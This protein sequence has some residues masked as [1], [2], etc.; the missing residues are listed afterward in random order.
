M[1]TSDCVGPL[2]LAMILLW[3]GILFVL[4][5]PHCPCP[6]GLWKGVVGT[7]CATQ[8]HKVSRPGQG[9]SWG[10]HSM[11]LF[12]VCVIVICVWPGMVPNQRQLSII[13]SDW[14]PYLGSLFS[15]Y[16]LWV[17]VFCVCISPYRTVSIFIVSLWLFCISVFSYISIKWTLTT[18]RFGLVFHTPPQ[19]KKIVTVTL[20]NIPNNIYLHLQLKVTGWLSLLQRKVVHKSKTLWYV[21]I[22]F[23]LCRFIIR[24]TRI[25]IC[26]P[27]VCDK[28]IWFDSLG[29]QICLFI[30]S[31]LSFHC[32]YSCPGGLCLCPSLCSR[33]CPFSCLCQDPPAY[34]SICRPSD[35]LGL[36][37][38]LVSCS[39]LFNAVS[40]V[41]V[42]RMT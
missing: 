38:T 8:W 33:T 24:Y 25:N 4:L 3:S 6:T 23:H 39:H 42:N 13:V 28:Y 19:M 40:A 20:K 27:C 5:M 35:N 15:H 10:G 30:F 9:V 31:L 29:H 41:H 26:Q 12:Y 2:S 18:L 7:S 1:E 14:E 32:S 36:R 21:L 16:G 37:L 11:F 17:D 34:Y 22:T